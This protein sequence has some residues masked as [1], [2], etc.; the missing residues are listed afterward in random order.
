[1]MIRLLLQDGIMMKSRVCLKV[2]KNIR[3]K[4]YET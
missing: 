3:K 4:M 1:M 2:E